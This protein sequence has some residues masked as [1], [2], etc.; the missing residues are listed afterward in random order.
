MYNER[1]ILKIFIYFNTHFKNRAHKERGQ[2][3]LK[4]SCSLNKYLLNA[5]YVYHSGTTM[6]TTLGLVRKLIPKRRKIMN[7]ISDKVIH[8]ME[9]NMAGW[10]YCVS[11]KV[12]FSLSDQE[13][14]IKVYT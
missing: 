3:D 7:K 4:P 8:S 10:T 11:G 2:V 13:G 6:C 1:Q 5:Y 9:K 14:D 12:P